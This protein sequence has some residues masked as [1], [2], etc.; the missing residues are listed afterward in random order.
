M[1]MSRRLGNLF[2]LTLLGVALVCAGAGRSAGRATVVWI[3]IDGLRHDYVDRFKPPFL[4]RLS[5]EGAF[6]C[7][8]VPVFPSL[9]FPS[10]MSQAT[11]VTADRHG[12]PMNSFLDSSNGQTHR[13]PDDATLVQA[14]PIWI[15]AARQGV[16]TAVIDWPL[17]HKQTP[18]PVRSEYFGSR[19]DKD[20]TDEQ[21]L[22][23]LLKIWRDDLARPDAKQPLRLVMGYVAGPDV[24]AHQHGPDAAETRAAVIETD[25][26]L[27][28]FTRDATELFDRTAAP[29]DALYILF[30]TDH[31]M[32]KVH[33]K[34]NLE[35]LLS[36]E[37]S[38]SMRVVSA[39]TV[40]H[41]WLASDLPDE[42][43]AAKQKAIVAKLAPHR[44]LDAWTRD[45][46][47]DRFG[48]RHP[49]RIGD[50][51]VSLKPG[52]TWTS[53]RDA[54][55]RPVTRADQ[56]AT[57]GYD[58]DHDPDM[59]GYA[60]VWR[61]GRSLEGRDLGRVESLRLHATVAHLLA[62]QPAKDATGPPI[63]I[64]PQLTPPAATTRASR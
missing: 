17:S 9:T 56:Q 15:T 19:F 31:G 6:T 61:R 55:T 36:S 46:L 18:L 39:G 40:A 60:I 35:R 53:R 22:D 30:T 37:Y 52:Y 54:A 14:E 42:Q 50:V 43:R 41:L 63:S 47:P 34:V 24:V 27:E 32:T 10:H 62:I 57:H 26:L 64:E 3:S 49:T 58:V 2:V 11:G 8:L 23:A 59:M 16:R 48:Y 51:V 13:Y 25:R 21:R 12:V 20:L 4:T 38:A 7:Q 44:F 29:D 33:T 28:R 5:R 1:R 45:G